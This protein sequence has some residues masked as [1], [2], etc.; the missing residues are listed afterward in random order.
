[1]GLRIWLMVIAAFAVVIAGSLWWHAVEGPTTI[2]ARL[3]ALAPVLALF[4]WAG[5]AVVVAG[6]PVWVDCF[7]RQLSPEKRAH[8]KAYRWRIAGWLVVL[9]LVLGQQLLA[10]IVEV[11]Q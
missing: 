3:A 4:R 10:R 1:M 8:L 5:I 9:E 2:Q 6:W 7:G 11:I